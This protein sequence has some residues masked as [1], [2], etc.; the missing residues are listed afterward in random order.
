MANSDKNILVTPS[1][2]LSTNPT[3]KFNGANNTPT[4]LRVLDDVTVSF[5]QLPCLSLPVSVFLLSR[6]AKGS[7]WEFKKE[8]IIESKS[9][10]IL[11]F[12]IF[13]F[14]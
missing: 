11:L 3:I 13:C 10:N 4:T 7:N 6:I 1:V 14:F 12:D 2:G 8:F 9:S 5:D